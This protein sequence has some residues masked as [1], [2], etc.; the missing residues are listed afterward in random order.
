[1]QEVQALAAG[2][3]TRSRKK[4]WKGMFKRVGRAPR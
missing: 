2:E 3:E 1:V 4:G